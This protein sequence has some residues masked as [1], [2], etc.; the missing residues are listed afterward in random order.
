M[1]QK[2]SR[3]CSLA[4][5]MRN[6]YNLPVNDITVSTDCRKGLNPIVPE[7]EWV[8]TLINILLSPAKSSQRSVPIM[9]MAVAR[10]GLR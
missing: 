3:V 10:E 1:G 6:V 4:I 2:R 5:T 8:E 9:A 7:V